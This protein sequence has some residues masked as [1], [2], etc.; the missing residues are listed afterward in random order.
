GDVEGARRAQRVRRT[1]RERQ[2]EARQDAQPLLEDQ[3]EVGRPRPHGQRVL[4][5]P[6]V[7]VGDGPGAEGPAAPL[8]RVRGADL[9]ARRCAAPAHPDAPRIRP[10]VGTPVPAVTSTLCTSPGWFTDVPRS[11][12]TASAMPF[13]PWM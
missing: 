1:L 3:V 11:S 2:R 10:L 7:V 5:G 9:R 4:D 6:G 13:I 12:R 8:P